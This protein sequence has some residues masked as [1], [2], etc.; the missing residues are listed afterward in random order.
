VAV[1]AGILPEAVI[2]GPPEGELRAAARAAGRRFA[3]EGF[4]DRAYRTD[5][6]LVPRGEPGAVLH[7]GGAVVAQALAL[8]G[9]GRV[10]TLCVHGDG[11]SATRLLMAARGA[12]VAAGFRIAT[13]GA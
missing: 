1:V 6:S 9:G 12:L 3:A 7:D 10:E 5:G 2:F 11:P 13:V 8:A 4:V